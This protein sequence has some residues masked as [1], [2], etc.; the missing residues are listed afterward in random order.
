MRNSIISTA[1]DLQ[2]TLDINPNPNGILPLHLLVTLNTDPQSVM[3]QRAG[4]RKREGAVG[5][6]VLASVE[7]PS[8]RVDS[9][10][11]GELAELMDVGLKERQVSFRVQQHMYVGFSYGQAWHGKQ[12]Q[13]VSLAISLHLSKHLEHPPPNPTHAAAAFANTDR[14]LENRGWTC[15]QRPDDWHGRRH[16]HR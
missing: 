14:C 1:G 2:G 7:N 12:G 13:C 11:K 3:V 6:S 16:R 15:G 10:S 8:I 4:Q 5:G 9:S